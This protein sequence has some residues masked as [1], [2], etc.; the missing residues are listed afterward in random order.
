MSESSTASVLCS[1]ISLQAGE[2]LMATA[3]HVEVWFALETEQNFGADAFP[4]AQLPAAVRAHL[5]AALDATPR[6]R[7]QMLRL[8][9]ERPRTHDY[10]FYVAIGRDVNPLLYKFQLEDY[11]D[12]LKIDLLKVVAGDAE[13]AANLTDEPLFLICANGKRDRCCARF[14]IPIYE[15]MSSYLASIGLQHTLWTTSHIGGHRFA[16]TGVFLP[17]GICYGRMKP[18]EAANFVES[19][20]AGDLLLDYLRGRSSYA[21]HVQA[22]EQFIRERTGV[23]AILALRLLSDERVGEKADKHWR[24]SFDVDGTAHTVDVKEVQSSFH[25]LKS[26]ADASTTQVPQYVLMG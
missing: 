22:A 19:Y 14:G 3:S 16:G 2:P 13:Y 18:S 26:S 23:T 24:I 25:T 8:G 9:K 7:M 12:L 10:A 6:S 5:K 15:A 17:A 4:E 1:E 11:E 21:E 20:R